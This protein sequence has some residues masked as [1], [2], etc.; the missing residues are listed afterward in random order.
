M[1]R[2]QFQIPVVSA[3]QY[4][5]FKKQDTGYKTQKVQLVELLKRIHLFVGPLDESINILA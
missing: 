3:V 5:K 2:A 1:H 4:T